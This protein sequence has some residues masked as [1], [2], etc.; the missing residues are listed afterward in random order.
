MRKGDLR[1]F[2]GLDRLAS[3]SSP[4][5]EAVAGRTFLV[6]SAT[7]EADWMSFLID[8]RLEEGWGYRFVQEHSEV[9]SDQG[10]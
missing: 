1:R 3:H 4:S 9:I 5:W 10:G 2:R 6:V 7:G 8:G